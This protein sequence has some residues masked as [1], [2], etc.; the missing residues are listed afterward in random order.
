MIVLSAQTKFSVIFNKIS[1]KVPLT[2]KLKVKCRR[3]ND[4]LLPL[5]DKRKLNKIKNQC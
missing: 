2:D 5:D 4:R 1:K 3:I